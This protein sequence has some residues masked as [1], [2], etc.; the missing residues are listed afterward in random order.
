MNRTADLQKPVGN[1]AFCGDYTHPLA[2]TD[3]ANRSALRAVND[4]CA[5][6]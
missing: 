2:H 5:M 3:S 4:V 6:S 1:V